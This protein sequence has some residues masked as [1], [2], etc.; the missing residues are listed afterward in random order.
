MCARGRAGFIIWK[1][2]SDNN[3]NFDIQDI[4]RKPG[5][6]LLETKIQKKGLKISQPATA[7][8]AGKPIIIL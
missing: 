8:I 2:F 5:Y 1:T 6:N 7:E 4:V 3:T